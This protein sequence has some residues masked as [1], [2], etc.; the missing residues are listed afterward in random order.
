MKLIFG[1][2]IL[3]H[4]IL[5][6]LV[7]LLGSQQSQPFVPASQVRTQRIPQFENEQVKVWRSI[8]TPNAPLSMHRHEH[9]RVIIAL[10]G[11]TMNIVEDNGKNESHAWETGKAYW[12]PAN[13]PNTM[14]ADVNK[15]DQ[16][17]EVMVV[18]LKHEK[19]TWQSGWAC[20][21]FGGT[22]LY[23]FT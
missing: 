7:G 15:G 8:I 23:F 5:I 11:G 3:L 20:G 4:V 17:I 9:P 13:R 19:L 2:G 18:E 10:S 22:L 21:A 1:R 12:L 14:H 6:S 16:P